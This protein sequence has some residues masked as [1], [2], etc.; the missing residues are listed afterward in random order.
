MNAIP[1]MRPGRDEDVIAWYGG[2]AITRAQFLHDV[3]VLAERLPNRTHVLNHCENRYH[4]LMGFAAA[5]VRGQISLFPANTAPQVL[6]QLSRDYP[7][8]YCLSERPDEVQCMDKVVCKHE[9][10]AGPSAAAL[11]EF[12]IPYEQIATIVFTS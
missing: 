5:L 6:E 10:G 2:K 1:F 12:A 3:A 9:P 8:A 11:R 7:G 4:F